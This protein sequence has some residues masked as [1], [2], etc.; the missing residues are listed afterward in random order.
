MNWLPS[1]LPA[2]LLL[3]SAALNAASTPAKALLVVSKGDLTLSIVDPVSLKV[4]SSSP[5]GPDPHE[6][7]VSPDGKFAYISNYGGGSYNM[8]TVVDLVAQ[9]TVETIDLG[10]LHGPHGLAYSGGRVWFTAEVN[11]LIGSYDPATKKV[12]WL[13]G[14]GQNRTHMLYVSSDQKRIFTTNVSSAT[15]SIIDKTNAVAGGG[16]GPAGVPPQA[17]WDQVAIGV[18][19]GAEG[20]DVSPDGKEVWTANA[21][22][23]TVSVVDVAS[24]K[25][26]ETIAAG[27]KGANRLK[28]TP[29]G[30]LVLV[31]N[32]SGP[33]AIVI[34][35]ASRA[36]T[37]RIPMG[38]GAAGIQMQPDGTRAFFACTPDNYV[39]IVDLKTLEVTGHFEAGKNPDGLAW[40]ELKR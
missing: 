9:K 10:A 40:S 19:P 21:T 7:V 38:H 36:V 4:V 37:K 28:F 27:A 8:I 17:E 2:A 3:A 31:S 15:V 26:V 35:V 25:V 18:G 39:A 33:D 29:D 11:K 12:D 13:L 22:A 32:L 14:T 30:K 20:F 34:D 16:R 1:A 23:G 24:R 5:S 6:V